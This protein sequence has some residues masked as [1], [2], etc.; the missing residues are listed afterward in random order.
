MG[1][2]VS[3]CK[4]I[5]LKGCPL[6]EG[7]KGFGGNQFPK[8]PYPCRSS[9]EISLSK[10][11]D[12]FGVVALP[13]AALYLGVCSSVPSVSFSDTRNMLGILSREA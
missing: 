7:R 3:C 8:L 11:D 13:F 1:S 12:A 5:S 2:R 10:G 4:Y 6:P 9:N